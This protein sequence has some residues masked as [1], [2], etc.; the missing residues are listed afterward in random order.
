MWLVCATFKVA[1]RVVGARRWHPAV[2]G[3]RGVKRA[4]KAGEAEH[5][6]AHSRLPW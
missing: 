2:V 4:A 3:V 1:V 6:V 5:P